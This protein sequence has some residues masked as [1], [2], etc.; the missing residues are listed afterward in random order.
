MNHRIPASCR[1]RRSAAIQGLVLLLVL[2]LGLPLAPGAARAASAF[3]LDPAHSAL[4]FSI[5]HIFTM[6]PG[7]FDKFSTNIVFDEAAPEKSTVEVTIDAASVTTDNARRDGDLRSANFFNVEKFPTLTFKSTKVEKT[8][9]PSIYKVIGDFTML[10]VTKP[11]TVLAEILGVGP[12][13]FGNT[14]AGFQV[15]GTLN[16]KDFGMV[17]NKA[18]DTGNT[19]LGDE[20]KFQMAVEAVKKVS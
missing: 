11:V 18:L 5:R 14:K 3:D 2:L 9:Q 15:T 6:V 8:E 10:G 12:D 1:T 4:G 17:W 20:V 16:R 7:R 19:L 13:G